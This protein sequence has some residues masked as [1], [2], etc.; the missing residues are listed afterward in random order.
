MRRSRSAEQCLWLGPRRHLCGCRRRIAHTDADGNGDGNSDTH[1]DSN[2]NGNGDSDGN[3][4]FD[5]HG[6]SHAHP[7]RKTHALG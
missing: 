7:Q 1:G 5:S 3:A 2:G 4:Y 6:Y